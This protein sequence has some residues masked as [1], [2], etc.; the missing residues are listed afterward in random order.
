MDLA[1]FVA[2][3]TEI[4][5]FLDPH[6]SDSPLARRWLTVGPRMEDSRARAR[7][8]AVDPG[9]RR[10]WSAQLGRADQKRELG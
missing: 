8:C 6:V 2:T 4:P 10:A 3:T 9:C 1:G 7:G 5:A